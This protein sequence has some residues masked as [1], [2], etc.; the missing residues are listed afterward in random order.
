MKNLFVVILFSLLFST[1]DAQIVSVRNSNG[2]TFDYIDTITKKIISN[3]SYDQASSFVEGM[4]RVNRNGLFGFI[5]TKGEEVISCKYIHANDFS[6]GLV[7]VSIG[8]QEITENT[9]WVRDEKYGVID[10]TG[11]KII[12]FEFL[13]F[14]NFK[15]GIAR[16]RDLATRKWGWVDNKGKWNI[17]PKFEYAADFNDLGM[18]MVVVDNQSKGYINRQGNFVI[19]PVYYELGDF[20]DGIAIAK[21]WGQKEKYN[22][23]YGYINSKGETIVPF[24]YD[25]VEGFSENLALVGKRN[26]K[27][28]LK[29]GFIDK[30]GVEQITLKYEYA[31]SFSNGMAFVKQN[32]KYG[33]IN[34]IGKYVISNVYD[35]AEDFRIPEDERGFWIISREASQQKYNSAIVSKDGFWGVIDISGKEILQLVYDS[36]AKSINGYIAI[37]NGSKMFFEISGKKNNGEK[38]MNSTKSN[39]VFN[40]DHN[41]TLHDGT[42]SSVS[43]LKDITWRRTLIGEFI[44]GVSTCKLGAIKVSMNGKKYGI[45]YDSGEIFSRFDYDSIKAIA[46]YS[47][48]NCGIVGY[49]KDKLYIL[50]SSKLPYGN[51]DTAITISTDYSIIEN[52]YEY[53]FHP[54]NLIRVKKGEGYGVIYIKDE[55]IQELVKPIFQDI[56]MLPCFSYKKNNYGL[57]PVKQNGVWGFV[58]PVS[59]QIKIPCQYQNVGG[60]NDRDESGFCQVK[61]NNKWG[62]I[63]EK[64]VPISPIMYDDA[65]CYANGL[66]AVKK[67]GKWGFINEYGSVVT[68][69]IYESVE[70]HYEWSSCVKLNKM[71]IVVDEHGNWMY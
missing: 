52:Y 6:E 23:K 50:T 1:A 57:V 3:Y 69:C 24:I 10:K 51:I 36:I 17:I 46:L 53:T 67:D 28:E 66:C 58:D 68:P 56:G 14:D 47:D 61:K 29:F 49:K 26:I 44:S 64:G 32:S 7:S 2:V 63:N 12:P 4:A 20:I 60:F 35:I 33:W 70:I 41:H 30:K 42:G 5:N 38:I 25:K 15:N 11:Q 8:T 34:K 65:L 22:G 62:I 43:K 19:N 31:H 18:A 39:S 9:I 71:E 54:S 16:A 27:G 13:E 37:K 59:G 55:K 48:I 21:N 40:P 45:I